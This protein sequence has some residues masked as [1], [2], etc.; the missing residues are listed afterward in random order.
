VNKTAKQRLSQSEI[1]SL[2][3]QASVKKQLGSGP[4]LLAPR[5]QKQEAKPA[6]DS[7]RQPEATAPVMDAV[8]GKPGQTENQRQT[9]VKTPEQARS[10]QTQ[11]AP[12]AKKENAQPAAKSVETPARS[13]DNH[14][15]DEK[16]AAVVVVSSSASAQGSPL[17]LKQYFWLGGEGTSDLRPDRVMTVLN[18]K[19]SRLG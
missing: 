8:A 5:P 6:L 15:K 19:L 2:V 4:S 16:A 9:P 3:Q 10:Q 14:N 1:D 17:E 7:K 11:S 13:E 18:K 12:A